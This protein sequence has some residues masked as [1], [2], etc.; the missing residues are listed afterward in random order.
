V[1]QLS[2]P[3]IFIF[4]KNAIS[5]AC[6]WVNKVFSSVISLSKYRRIVRLSLKVLNYNLF[7]SVSRVGT[8]LVLCCV[9]LWSSWL[10]RIIINMSSYQH[11]SGSQKRKER[12]EK[13]KNSRKGQ[14][15]L[16]QF[17]TTKVPTHSGFFSRRVAKTSREVLVQCPCWAF[18]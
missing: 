8:Y 7:S 6:A 2:F 14:L 3:F 17:F 1:V 5:N 15:P 18:S 11:K 9:L 10:S 4:C 16:S 13:D 12:E